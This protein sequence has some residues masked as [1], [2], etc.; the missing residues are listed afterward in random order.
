M[1]VGTTETAEAVAHRL[2][3]EV[4]PVLG[5]TTRIDIG[6]P[7]RPPNAEAQPAATAED[8]HTRT[9]QAPGAHPAAKPEDQGQGRDRRHRET[10]TIE[11]VQV[12]QR[13]ELASKTSRSAREGRQRYQVMGTTLKIQMRQGQSQPLMNKLGWTMA[14]HRSRTE[15]LSRMAPW[16]PLTTMPEPVISQREAQKRR[17]RRIIRAASESMKSVGHGWMDGLSA[18]RPSG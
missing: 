7:R 15:A 12:R 16:N 18:V 13:L 4:P 11:G 8:R 9:M 5:T 17:S 6:A 2:E 14:L 3:E 10:T 1:V